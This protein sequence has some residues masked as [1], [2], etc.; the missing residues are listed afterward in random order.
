MDQK[1]KEKNEKI[2]KE[3]KFEFSLNSNEKQKNWKS[4]KR[5]ST[6]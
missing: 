6:K 2:E 4:M 5:K 3:L 1:I